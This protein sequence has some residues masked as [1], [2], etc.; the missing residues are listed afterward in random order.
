MKQAH[1]DRRKRPPHP[2]GCGRWGSPEK[3]YLTGNFNSS[4][5]KSYDS[6]L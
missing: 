5:W 6:L 3:S 2:G 4:A 1:F